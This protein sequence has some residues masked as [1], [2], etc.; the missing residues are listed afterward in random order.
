MSISILRRLSCSSR[1]A[2]RGR[3]GFG[4][5]PSRAARAITASSG[6]VLERIGH[7]LNI[8]WDE[9]ADRAHLRRAAG[10]R[11]G[12]SGLARADPVP[13]AQ[14]APAKQ[15]GRADRDAARHALH[16]GGRGRDRARPARRR[17]G[18]ER[19]RRPADRD[20][21][22]AVV[23]GRHRQPVPAESGAG[24]DVAP[25][26]LA[27]AGD[28]GRG[29]AA[30]GRPSPAVE[31]LS[32]RARP[33]LPVARLGRARQPLRHRGRDDSPGQLPSPRRPARGRGD[34]LP[35]RPRVDHPRG[36]GAG[37]PRRLRRAREP[38]RMVGRRRRA[39]DHPRG[40]RHGPM[41]ARRS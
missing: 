3:S 35:A 37:G 32:D 26:P 30:R 13:G 8:D 7:E 2:T 22:H 41:A 19:H 31:G 36:L 6:R 18:R 21:G 10:G 9:A 1:P 11:D 40:D 17:L 25:G 24:A 5:R 38:T 4:P 20:R 29:R 23:V 28:R 12:L 27:H 33:A 34:R 15:R 39:A 16:V 14:R